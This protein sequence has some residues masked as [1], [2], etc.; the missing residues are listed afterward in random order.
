MSLKTIIFVHGAWH[1]PKFFDKV[2]GILEPHGYRCV[3]V[4]LPGTGS[5]PT[6]KNLDADNAAVREVVLKEIDAGNDVMV[7]AHSWGGLPACSALDGLSKAEREGNG[8]QGAVT[9]LSFVSS[10]V[11]PE[12]WSI[13]DALGGPKEEWV[14]DEV[15]RPCQPFVKEAF[16]RSD[17]EWESHVATRGYEGYFLP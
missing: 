9:K 5:V 16:L 6:V 11:L 2:I 17:T 7:N 14:P 4:S 1:S 13:A 10:F 15:S 8:K 3:V 12:G